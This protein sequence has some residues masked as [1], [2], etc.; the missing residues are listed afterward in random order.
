[1]TTFTKKDFEAIAE[2]IKD[3]DLPTGFIQGEDLRLRIAEA[4]ARMLCRTSKNPSF[5]TDR[6]VRACMINQAK[7]EQP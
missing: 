7:G 1:V 3:L 4:F 5:D 2:T 6:F